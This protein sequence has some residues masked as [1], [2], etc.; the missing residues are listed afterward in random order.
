MKG[1]IPETQV[2]DA[3]TLAE[4][5]SGKRI[6]Y[7]IYLPLKM[8]CKDIENTNRILNQHRNEFFIDFDYKSLIKNLSYGFILIAVSKDLLDEL[9]PIMKKYKKGVIGSFV[10]IR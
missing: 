2:A 10:K 8:E 6:E 3:N 5:T 9:T 1:K 7:V 4:S